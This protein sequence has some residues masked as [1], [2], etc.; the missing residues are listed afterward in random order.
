MPEIQNI[1][2]TIG[3]GD[4]QIATVSVPM[5]IVRD[6]DE[7][8]LNLWMK[9]VATNCPLYAENKKEVGNHA[10]ILVEPEFEPVSPF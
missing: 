5:K 8:A 3:T 10:Q 7:E 1:K 6:I 2:Y 4:F 9:Q